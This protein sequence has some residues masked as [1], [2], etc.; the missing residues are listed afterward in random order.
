MKSLIFASLIGLSLQG[1]INSASTHTYSQETYGR[2]PVKTV[3]AS[4]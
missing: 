3:K 1:G 4:F 2:D